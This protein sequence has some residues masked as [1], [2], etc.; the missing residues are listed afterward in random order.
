MYHLYK[1]YGKHSY[2][3]SSINL[4]VKRGEFIFLTGASGAG[5]STFLKLLYL[6]EFPSR[7]QLIVMGRNIGKIKSAQIPFLRRQIGVVFQDFKLLPYRTVYDNIAIIFKIFGTYGKESRKIIFNAL[8]D[9]GMHKKMYDYPRSLSGG[10][11]QRV[12]MVRALINTPPL[13]LADE[14]TGNLH[15]ELSAEVIKLLK[16][17]NE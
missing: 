12:A 10:E 15:P 5:K 16:R 3:L 13:I 8:R 4:K 9:V 6:E 14:P 11:Q 1:S 7:G 2:A 17:I